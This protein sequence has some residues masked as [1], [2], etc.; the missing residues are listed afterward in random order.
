[1]MYTNG[2]E[3]LFLDSDKM[4]NSWLSA[5]GIQPWIKKVQ[6]PTKRKAGSEW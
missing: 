4:R 3:V 1:M 6:E 2:D 5:K